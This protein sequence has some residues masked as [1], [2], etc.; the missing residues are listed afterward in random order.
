MGRAWRAR[1]AGWPALVLA[2]G[3]A[4]YL[5]RHR[6]DDP[7]ARPGS[8]D[9][10]APTA[11]RPAPASSDD[12]RALCLAAV[13]ADSRVRRAL[14]ASM[15]KARA[16]PQRPE[17]WVAAGHA[18]M[19]QLRNSGDSGFALNAEA[20]AR[21]AQEITPDHPGALGLIALVRLDAHDFARARDLAESLIARDPRDA[22]ALG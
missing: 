12:A 13:P 4:V 14:L 9:L 2:L 5:L 17:H 10:A 15:G 11:S 7:L 6:G 8:V 18:W 19:S 20:C 22:G 3:A 16:L 21:V 1:R